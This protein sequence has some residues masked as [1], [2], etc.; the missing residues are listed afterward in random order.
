MNSEAPTQAEL[1]DMTRYT[2]FRTGSKVQRYYQIDKLIMGVKTD[3]YWVQLRGNKV[4]CNC[5]GF[6]RQSFPAIDHKHVKL[7]QDF[8]DR[9]EP[10]GA[11]YR[12]HGTGAKAQIEFLGA[13]S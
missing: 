1:I 8:F 6:N 4:Y 9:G 10:V 13:E 5:P 11:H 3:D 7:A 12:I 2:I